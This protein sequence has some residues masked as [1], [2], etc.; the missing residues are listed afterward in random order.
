MSVTIITDGPL[1]ISMSLRFAAFKQRKIIVRSKLKKY[2]SKHT[3]ETKLHNPHQNKKNKKQP[4][5]KISRNNEE[6]N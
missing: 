6:F 2:Q 5:E 1:P 4:Q 3:A